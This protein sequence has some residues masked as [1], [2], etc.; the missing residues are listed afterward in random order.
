M[1][2][3]VNIGRKT[4]GLVENTGSKGNKLYIV[5]NVA[6]HGLPALA[7]FVLH[8]ARLT[9]GIMQ[10]R[11]QRR[12]TIIAVTSATP[13]CTLFLTAIP[14][15]LYHCTIQYYYVFPQ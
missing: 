14:T 6:T 3:G 11:T 12:H 8:M 2:F 10:L 7:M 9:A 5:M 4:L 13:V 1:P 15:V